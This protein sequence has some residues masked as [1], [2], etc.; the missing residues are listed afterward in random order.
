V[1]KKAIAPVAKV[2]DKRSFAVGDYV[3][4]PTHGVGRISGIEVEVIGQGEGLADASA[5]HPYRCI[6]TGASEPIVFR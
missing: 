6:P 5:R 3:V 4:Y 1:E 2:V